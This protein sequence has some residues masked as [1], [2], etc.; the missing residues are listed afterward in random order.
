MTGNGG[1]IPFPT[2]KGFQLAVSIQK[3]RR[4]FYAY[5][6]HL[7]G[8]EHLIGVPQVLVEEA[9]MCWRCLCLSKSLYG[10]IVDD[11]QHLTPDG[12]LYLVGRVKAVIY[13]F[14][15][16]AEDIGI[17]A[18]GIIEGYLSATAACTT[19]VTIVVA[20]VERID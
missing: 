3:L 18:D 15:E 6:M 16:L 4:H 20:I 12:R 9:V 7:E 19:M 11:A 8:S 14:Q 5:G 13:L 1:N 10:P 17:E 2:V